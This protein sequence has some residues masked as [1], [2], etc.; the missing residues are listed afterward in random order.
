MVKKNMKQKSKG[1]N[2]V[3]GFKNIFSNETTDFLLGALLVLMAIYVIIAMSS[4]LTTGQADQ[5]I[6]EDMRPGDWL[7]SDRKFTNYCG[8]IGALISYSLI[9]INFGYAAFFI[10]IFFILVGLK[11]MKVY[12]VNLWK[13]FLAFAVVMLWCSVFFAKFLTV[14]FSESVYNP[15]GNHGLFVSQWIENIVGTPG[16]IV[17]LALVA[18][19]FLVFVSSETINVIRNILNPK[20]YLKK[21]KFTIKSTNNDNETENVKDDDDIIV[22]DEYEEEKIS[23]PVS[24]MDEVADDNENTEVII[25]DEIQD[26]KD[27]VDI[28]IMVAEEGEKA[29]KETVM[30]AEDINS[31]INPKEPFTNYKYPTLSLLKKYDNDNQ[32]YVD[33]AELIKKKDRIIEVLRS[34]KVE[35]S[36]IDATVG[37]TITLYEITPAEGIRISKIRGLS[38]DLALNLAAGGAEFAALTAG[39]MHIV[40]DRLKEKSPL[41]LVG[42][43]QTVCDEAKRMGYR[44]VGLMG[45]IF[46]MEKDFFK[47]ALTENG[48]EVIVP[49]KAQRE[50]I[51]Q[52]ITTELELGIV[53]KSTEEEFLGIIEQM[54]AAHGIDALIL[55]CTELPLILGAHNCPLP[56]LDIMAIHINSLAGMILSEEG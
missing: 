36:K 43:P 2:D 47:S 27:K 29:T 18:I 19:V 16:L 6:L 50:L 21:V 23:Q 12:S 45:T 26:N 34:F 41:P 30:D 15:G 4:Y 49:D 51:N 17:V 10:P 54:R 32:P 52:R 44:K 56:V 46:T 53:N 7:N 24:L 48:I 55:G 37:P 38:D 5:S 9:T 28:N 22:R 20:R 31:P 42:I 14:L 33:K 40:F 25:E 11:L 13:W 1:I 3:V 35:I 8:S 39:T